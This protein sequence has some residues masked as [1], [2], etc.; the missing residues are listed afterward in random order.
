[1]LLFAMDIKS[2]GREVSKSIGIDKKNENYK[3]CNALN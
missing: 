1:M 3:I 2:S